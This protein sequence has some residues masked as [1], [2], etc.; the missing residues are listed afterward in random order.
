MQKRLADE[1]REKFGKKYTSNDLTNYIKDDV[2]KAYQNRKCGVGSKDWPAWK[3]E[4][5]SITEPYKTTGN[6]MDAATTI[7]WP[8]SGDYGRKEVINW[9]TEQGFEFLESNYEKGW[10]I[11]F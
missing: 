4:F 1:I 8:K 6:A 9:F 11:K 10:R 3:V 5:E 2:W 7:H